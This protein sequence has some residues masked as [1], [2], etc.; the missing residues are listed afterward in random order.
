MLVTFLI[1]LREGIEAALIIGIMAGYSVQRGRASAL[2]SIWAG[3]AAALLVSALG[4]GLLLWTRA[5]FPQRAQETF[6]A[7]VALIA[8]IVLLSMDFWMRR[9]GRTFKAGIERTLEHD[10]SLATGGF[11][12]ALFATAFLIVWGVYRFS[13]GGSGLGSC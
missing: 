5:D 12:L 9:A 8:I 1:M 6:E 11:S 13:V 3:S 7:L 4:A 10:L 2:P